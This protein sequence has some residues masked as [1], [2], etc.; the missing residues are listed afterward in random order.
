[1]DLFSPSTLDQIGVINTAIQNG[2]IDAT[3]LENASPVASS[4][5]IT[6]NWN[7]SSDPFKENLFREQELPQAIE[8]TG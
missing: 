8:P 3:V 2:D 4:Q 7:K 5:F 1:M 6:F